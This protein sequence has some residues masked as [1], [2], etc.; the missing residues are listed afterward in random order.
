MSDFRDIL[1]QLCRRHDLSEEQSRYA[2]DHLMSGTATEA[3][4][5]GFLVG[6]AAKGSTVDELVG[7]ATVMRSRVVPIPTAPNDVIL[8]T[9]GTGGDVKGTFNISTAA[10]IV[11]AAAGVK[12]VKH[13]NRS[14]SGKTGSADVLEALGVKLDSTAAVQSACLKELNLCF[15]F[16]RGHHPAMK[17]VAA[18]RASLG[19]PTLFNVLGP[20]TNPAGA[21]HQL[22]GVFAP[23]LTDRLARVLQRLGSARAWVVY[24]EDGLDEISTTCPTHVS[25]LRDGK[26]NSRVI[27]AADL[28][29]PRASIDDLKV[30]SVTE[31]AAAIRGIVDGRRGPMRD[32]ALLNAAAAI[33]IAGAAD[34]LSAGLSLAANAVDSDRA[35]A[36][37]ETLA[38]VTSA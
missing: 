20:L 29:L 10:A 27:E 31:A 26:V 6:L 30:G 21:K 38:T 8:D 22:I 24:A 32:I 33:V 7:A 23:E 15:A 4:I 11:A 34:D 5:G 19:I 17:H 14:A 9:C 18:A 2:F 3:Q 16:A 37:L 1:L 25:E 35:R 36:V 12:V 28:G 13:G